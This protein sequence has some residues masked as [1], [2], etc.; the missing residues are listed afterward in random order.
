[1]IRI[2]KAPGPVG[3]PGCGVVAEAHDRMSVEY[4]DLAVFGRPARLVWSKPRWRCLET[5]CT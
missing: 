5:E 4:L 2:E 3:C 1:M